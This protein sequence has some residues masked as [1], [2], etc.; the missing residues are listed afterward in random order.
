LKQRI[1]F[2][3]S[4]STEDCAALVS[5]A[6]RPDVDVVALTLDVGQGRQLETVRQASLDAGA[7]RVHVLDVRDEFAHDCIRGSLRWSTPGR[8]THQSVSRALIARTL[9]ETAR[10]EATSLIAH[11]GNA[12]DHT[13]IDA[14]ARAIDPAIRVMAIHGVT[15]ST[16]APGV[17]ATLWDRT[18]ESGKTLVVP[19]ARVLDRPAHLEISFEGGLPVAVN[20]VPMRPAELVESVT[21]IAGHHGVGRLVDDVTGAPCEAPA[22]VVLLA[23]HEALGNDA[24]DAPGATVRLELFRGHHRIVS[25]HHS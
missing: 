4:G 15:P 18:L 17:R 16:H 7:V 1:V 14:A 20:G 25:A 6:A 10:V 24:L 12:E 11:G 5:L 22:A 13:A 2:A 19:P 8:V 23:A 3:C 9:V 21:T